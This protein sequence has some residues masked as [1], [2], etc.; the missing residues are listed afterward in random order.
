MN[1]FRKLM[2]LG[3]CAVMVAG[4]TPAYGLSRIQGLSFAD[5]NT[6]YVGGWYYPQQGFVSYTSDGGASWTAT[7]TSTG[8]YPVSSIVAG[9]AGALATLGGYSPKSLSITNPGL[10]WSLGA[11]IYSY[12]IP[13]QVIRLDDGRLVAVGQLSAYNKAGTGW[14]GKVAFVATSDNQGAN[15]TLRS[16]G[17]LYGLLPSGYPEQT[18][19][20]MAD[21][22]ATSDGSVLWAVGNEWTSDGSTRGS[23]KRRLMYRSTDRGSTWTTQTVA[24][25]VELTCLTVASATT[26]YAFG[27]SKS[28]VKTT[29]SGGSWSSVASP[30]FS[31]SLGNTSIEAAHARSA[32]TLIVAGNATISGPSQLAKSVDGGATWVIGPELGP[33]LFGVQSLTD[34]HW[35]AVGS[36]ETIIHTRDGGA[37]WS[38]PAGEKPP[39]VALM[40]PAADFVPSASPVAISGTAD[41][42]VGDSPGVGVERVEVLIKRADGRSWNGVSWVSDDAWIRTSTADGWRNWT[43]SWTP[44]AV[45]MTAPSVVSVTARATDGIGLQGSSRVDPPAPP[46][47]NPPTAPVVTA[48]SPKT[49]VTLGRPSLKTTTLVRS[50]TYPVSGVLKPRHT[51]GT[52]P[53][54]V[55]AYRLVKG[56]YRYYKSFSATASNYSTY[57]KYSTKVRLPY[58]GKWRLRAYHPADTK[59]LATYSTYRYVTVR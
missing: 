20:S 8:G 49:K 38:Q 1:R 41:D 16:A 34:A 47:V 6:G 12:A 4:V 36:N 26:A 51:A 57:S 59:H 7:S 32:T 28:G 15:W 48:P 30:P 24:G 31:A 55:H 2:A 17:P 54:K 56:K 42:G 44:D 11:T 45:F 52:K 58:R 21:V 37:T 43:Y 10:K 27:A 22:D 46:V 23:Y 35:I 9:P 29:N 33:A 3:L 40:Q 53:V 14:H 19:A 39:V 50:R 25:T 5:G 18:W 13:R